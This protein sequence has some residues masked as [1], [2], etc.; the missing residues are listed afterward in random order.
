MGP[1]VRGDGPLMERYFRRPWSRSRRACAG[2]A[3]VM[4]PPARQAIRR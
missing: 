4:P 2:P 3:A 1:R